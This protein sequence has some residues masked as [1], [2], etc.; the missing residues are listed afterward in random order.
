M[1]ISVPEKITDFFVKYADAPDVFVLD[2]MPNTSYLN[3]KL[4]KG[5]KAAKADTERILYRITGAAVVTQEY[6]PLPPT[7]VYTG[8]DLIPNDHFVKVFVNSTQV[9]IPPSFGIS[10][11]TSAFTA[12]FET[13]NI[14]IIDIQVFAGGGKYTFNIEIDES[15]V[16]IVEDDNGT[17]TTLT[18]VP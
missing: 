1:S 17:Q 16:L 11:I 12:A 9:S 3:S 13:E 10:Q 6:P 18:L 15:A 7:F 2:D 5:I 14:G 4:E 8:V